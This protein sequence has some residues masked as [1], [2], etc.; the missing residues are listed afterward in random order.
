MLGLLR[1]ELLWLE[2]LCEELFASCLVKS[3]EKRIE[4]ALVEGVGGSREGSERKNKPC[5]CVR[6]EL[7]P[8]LSAAGPCARG[9]SSRRTEGEPADDARE[10]P[11]FFL[12]LFYF[13][14]VCVW[15]GGLVF[16]VEI[17]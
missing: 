10:V 6:K 2:P 14:I 16:K 5:V 11:F 3:R 12:S 13:G 4:R 1:E 7:F 17:V 15:C 9:G 8:E